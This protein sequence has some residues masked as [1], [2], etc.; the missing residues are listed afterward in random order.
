[1]DFISYCYIS[2]FQ[3]YL[4]LT[5]RP[6]FSPYSCFPFLYIR[7]PIYA[8]TLLNETP[9]FHFLSESYESQRVFH[10]FPVITFLLFTLVL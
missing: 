4:V 6:R 3:I 5:F 1:M 8:I 10:E 2:N 9:D 7:S